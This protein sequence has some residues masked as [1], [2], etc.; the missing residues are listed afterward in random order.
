MKLRPGFLPFRA[1][2]ATAIL[3][4]AFMVLA[5]HSSAAETVDDGI[6]EKTIEKS[7]ADVK[8][9]WS[10]A[11]LQ[12]AV[13]LDGPAPVTEPFDL[14]AFPDASTSVRQ[15]DYLVKNPLT[16]PK[17]FHGKVFFRIGN[18]IF[19]CSA[20]VISS[21]YGNAIFTAGHCVYDRAS[22][23]FVRDLLFIPAYTEGQAPLGGYA[24][25]SLA[26]TR[27]W[28]RGKS[29]AADIG[30]A[31]VSGTPVANLGGARPVAFN[32]KAKKRAYTIYGYPADPNPPFDGERMFGCHSKVVGRDRGKPKPMAVFPCYMSH[33]ASGGGWISKGYLNSVTSYVYCD[34]NPK[35]CGYLF[36]PYFSTAAKKLYRSPLVGGSTDPLIAFRKAPPRKLKR[37][38]FGIRMFGLAST[39]LRYQCAID[40]RKF[41]RCGRKARIG[42]LSRGRHVL[43]VRAY[44]QTGRKA[45]NQLKRK[46]RVTR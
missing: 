2:F 17:R 24:A 11:D 36:A 21:R 46:F 38:H 37:H 23:A 22:R 10:D 29:F 18:Q 4:A 43:R 31:T 25:A 30:I 34:T 9:S 27:N 39:P 42:H 40:R 3:A 28:K 12:N 33:G 32:L 44:D 20:T 19:T 15:G 14:P 35:Y 26:T 6:I 41:R 8:A 1:C 13:P 16:L 45:V 5:A 7:P